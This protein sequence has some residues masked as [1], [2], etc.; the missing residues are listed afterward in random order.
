MLI[1]HYNG[2]DKYLSDYFDRLKFL[3]YHTLY[4]DIEEFKMFARVSFILGDPINYWI[5][6]K[7]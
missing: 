5:I 7:N 4:Y 1:N 6:K 2:Y 3:N